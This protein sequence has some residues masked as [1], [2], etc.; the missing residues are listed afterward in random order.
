MARR[1]KYILEEEIFFTNS[2]IFKDTLEHAYNVKCFDGYA[3]ATAIEDF[4]GNENVPKTLR[5]VYPLRGDIVNDDKKAQKVLSYRGLYDLSPKDITYGDIMI[6]LGNIVEIKTRKIIN[7]VWSEFDK[8]I[9]NCHLNNYGVI[10]L[11]EYGC[12]MDIDD[13]EMLLHPTAQ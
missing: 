8:A 1:A 3:I 4:E 10:Y 7:N 2:K 11:D 6:C 13:V 5:L 9:G 12:P